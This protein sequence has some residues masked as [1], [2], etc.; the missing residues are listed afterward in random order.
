M[1]V[2]QK[3]ALPDSLE[4]PLLAFGRS[5]ARLRLARRLPQA[6]VAE[7]AGISRNTVSRIENGEPSVA[8]GQ[9]VRYLQALNRVDII[10]HLTN[11]PDPAVMALEAQEKRCRTRALTSK[12]LERYDF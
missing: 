12:E 11:A 5:L 6:H 4:Q 9:V 1:K 2:S 7:K 8:I 10:E 3:S